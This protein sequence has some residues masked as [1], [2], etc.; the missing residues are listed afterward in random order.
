[1]TGKHKG[2]YNDRRWKQL[3][4]ECW[5]LANGLCASCGKLVKVDGDQFDPDYYE[6]NHIV[7]LDEDLGLAFDIDNLECLHRAC[8]RVKTTLQQTTRM[9]RND[10]W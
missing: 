10:G 9:Q 6:C 2:I 4:Q 3:R 1:M 7:P 8:H 5:R